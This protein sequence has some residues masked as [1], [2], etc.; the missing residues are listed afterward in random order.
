MVIYLGGSLDA[1]HDCPLSINNWTNQALKYK[2]K[3]VPLKNLNVSALN[4]F[5]IDME[6]KIMCFPIRICRFLF[7][8]FF[9][10]CIPN[11]V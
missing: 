5:N 6:M 3:P 1:N 8:R 10:T 11:E 9:Y 4:Y 2:A 7:A